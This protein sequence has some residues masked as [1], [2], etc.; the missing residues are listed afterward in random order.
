MKFQTVLCILDFHKLLLAVAAVPEIMVQQVLLVQR[1]IN[2]HS[3]IRSLLSLAE[4]QEL[5]S[6][7][8]VLVDLQR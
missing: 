1:E 8:P 5:I 7:R 4:A 6:Q 3:E 2:P